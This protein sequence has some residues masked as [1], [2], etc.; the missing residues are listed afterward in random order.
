MRPSFNDH[1]MW[2]SYKCAALEAETH[3]N[4][5]TNVR[6]NEKL[7]ADQIPSFQLAN[8]LNSPLLNQLLSLPSLLPCCSLHNRVSD[9]AHFVVATKTAMLQREK[10]EQM[11]TNHFE[12][13]S[14]SLILHNLV[15]W[16]RIVISGKQHLQRLGRLGPRF[17]TR[18]QVSLEMNRC[19][20]MVD[21]EYIHTYSRIF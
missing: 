13:S 3:G 1:I 2:N 16:W 12:L 11:M 5:C 4:E 20:D 18:F 17:Q 7:S 6:V 10:R 19:L 14:L 9:F 15:S 8:A 21:I